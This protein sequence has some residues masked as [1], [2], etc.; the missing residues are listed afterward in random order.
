MFGKRYWRIRGYD[1]DN[2]TYEK[3]IPEGSLRESDI[4]ALLQRLSARHLAEDEIVSSSIRHS[5]SGYLPHLEPQISKDDHHTV[6]VG[7]GVYYVAGIFARN[8]LK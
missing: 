3:L 5:V 8:E 1:G 2:K 6:R 7:T 4:V